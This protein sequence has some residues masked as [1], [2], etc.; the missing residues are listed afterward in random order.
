MRRAVKAGDA[1]GL[2][3]SLDALVESASLRA[4]LAQA[5][6]ERPCS[7]YPASQIEKLRN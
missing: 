1:A 3:Q 7:L 2:A 4:T 6:P 5:G